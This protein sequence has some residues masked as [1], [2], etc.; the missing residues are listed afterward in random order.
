MHV[1]E[2]GRVVREAARVLRPGGLF[3]FHTFNRNPLHG[4][5]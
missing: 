4:S 2:P 3:F 5:S 1:E